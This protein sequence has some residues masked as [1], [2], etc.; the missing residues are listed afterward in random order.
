MRNS[1]ARKVALSVNILVAA[2]I[3]AMFA[4]YFA[5]T[6]ATEAFR[7]SQQHS[8]AMLTA[9]SEMESDIV[10]GGLRIFQYLESGDPYYLEAYQQHNKRLRQNLDKLVALGS[11]EAWRDISQAFSQRAQA[12]DQVG[13]GILVNHDSMSKALQAALAQMPDL[14]GA[15]VALLDASAPGSAQYAH[16]KKVEA[17]RTALFLAVTDFVHRDRGDG[18]V[19]ARLADMRALLA[20]YANLPLAAAEK[21][22][23]AE[24]EHTFGSFNAAMEQVLN[25]A[26]TKRDDMT[27][28]LYTQRQLVATIGTRIKPMLERHVEDADRHARSRMILVLFVA[29]GLSLLLALAAVLVGRY[30]RRSLVDP[31]RELATGTRSIAAGNLEHRVNIT[32]NDEYADLAA[33][34]NNMVSQLRGSMVSR[35]AHEEQASQLSALLDG[36]HDYAIF[37]V[38]DQGRITKWNTPSTRVLG[39]D[40]DDMEGGSFARIF[41]DADEARMARDQAFRTIAASGRFETDTRI[42]R[43]NGEVFDANL[44]A[45]PLHATDG[46]VRGYTVVVRDITE[47][48]KAER[49]IEELATTDTLTGLANRNML[50]EQL[51]AAIARASRSKTQIAVMFIDLDQFKAV[52]DT[53]GHAAGD[54]L[55]RECARRLHECVRKGDMVARFGGDE[56]VVLLTDIA[57]TASV[58]PVAERMLKSLSAPYRVLNQEARTSASIGICFYPTD[59]DDVTTL[60]KNADIAMYHAKELNRNNYQ[61]YAEEMNQRMLQRAQIERELRAALENN[62]FVL[63]YQPQV[64]VKSGEIHG[65]ESLI[66]WQHPTRG[67]LSPDKFIPVAEETGLILPIGEWV[68]NHTCETIKTWHASGVNIPYVG[69]N[70]S[71]AQLNDGLVALV[72]EALVKHG[73]APGW[74]VLEITET[75]LMER[76]DEA[77]AI[78]RRIRELGVRIAMD[79]FGTGYSSLSVLQRLPLDTLKIDRSFVSAIDSDIDNMRAIA[80]ISAIIAIAKELDV[81]VVAEG[82]ETPTQLAFLRTL[83]CDAYQ[84]YLFSKPVDTM[85]LEARFAAPVRSVLEDEQ[86]RAITLTTKVTLDLATGGITENTAP[87]HPD[88]T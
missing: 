37:S 87:L 71:A 83:D 35:A 62:E 36:V 18:S 76:V 68:L 57:T 5:A 82:V 69:V 59:G 74:L 28:L 67:L 40:A 24:L 3:I 72:R 7:E 38:D 81:S 70:V 2:A 64:S 58:T 79:D 86:G 8:Q 23:L 78:L 26:Q 48:V 31:I 60:M 52:N 46:A 51:A 9:S 84:G 30:L 56:F 27:K 32:T 34:F 54:E 45:T 63:H 75:M 25:I 77:I 80:I 21:R 66:R 65:A 4:A 39:Y 73:I 85:S 49:H 53:L 29:G 42:L 61:F 43:K 10:S 11:S 41:A 33:N 22:R 14:A 55:L 6:S 47:R 44:V 88:N 20:A 50:T 19:G 1:I 17:A 15:S 12:F 13:R 16:S